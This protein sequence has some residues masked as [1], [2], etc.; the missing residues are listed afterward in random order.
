M[1][2][3]LLRKAMILAAGEGTRLRPL[4][5][6]T[7]KVLV[8]IAGVPQIYYTLAWL[9]A[10]GIQEVA[11]NLCYLGDKVK[12]DLGDGSQ[13]GLKIRYSFEKTL[14]GT[15]GGVK[16][17]ENFFD[18]T[19]LVIYGDV[20]TDLNITAMLQYHRLKKSLAT[21]ALSHVPNPWE[22]GIVK[23]DMEGRVLSFVEKPPR[24]TEP[25]NLASGGIYILEKSVLDAVPD[26]GACD[27]AFDVFPE[28]LKTHQPVYGYALSPQDY[29]IDIGNWENYRKANEDVQ[30]NKLM[31]KVPS[32]KKNTG[33]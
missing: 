24:G 19:F 27:F 26:W 14:L 32:T 25:G 31:I 15:A 18:S 30:L 17:V 5:L 7:P 12:N 6:E 20:L 4:T 13:F 1:E 29:L 16:Q 28:L 33:G 2:D 22:K 8:P 21:L 3:K 10:Y 9:K 11:I 23:L